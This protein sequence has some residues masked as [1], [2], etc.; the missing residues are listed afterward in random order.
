LQ[1]AG[2][3]KRQY[4]EEKD[5]F[6]NSLS[7]RQKV[8]LS[9]LKLNHKAKKGEIKRS[10]LDSMQKDFLSNMPESLALT[11]RGV[12]LSQN[13][14]GTSVSPA[15]QSQKLSAAMNNW[16]NLSQSERD[17]YENIAEK[18]LMTYKSKLESFLS[19]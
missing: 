8:A 18:N 10:G 7:A 11:A 12:Y 9:L 17:V 5:N 19:N 4:T 1:K 2:E 15:E 6:V 14:K 16:Q 3:L 13:L